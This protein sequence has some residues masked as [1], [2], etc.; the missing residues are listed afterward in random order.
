VT[1]VEIPPRHREELG[2]FFPDNKADQSVRLI[3]GYACR[4][5]G[6][7]P[8]LLIQAKQPPLRD[9]FLRGL[10]KMAAMINRE[11]FWSPVRRGVGKH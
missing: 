8:L 11:A 9:W 6:Q 5:N 7:L 10:L 1:I 2:K 3:V 4:I